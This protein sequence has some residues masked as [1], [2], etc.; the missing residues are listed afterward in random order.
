LY[1]TD[2]KGKTEY[3]TET[4]IVVSGYSKLLDYCITSCSNHYNKELR[5][6]KILE[7][8]IKNK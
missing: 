6:I 5:N 3:I 1:C 2:P 7:T 8:R 4:E